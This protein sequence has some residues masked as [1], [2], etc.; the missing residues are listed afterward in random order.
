MLKIEELQSQIIAM[1]NP[2]A[3][4]LFGSQAKGTATERSDIDL[5]IIAESTNKR[6]LLADLYYSVET[7]IPVDFILYTPSEWANC[8]S[9]PHSF[10]YKIN[11]EGV[12]LYG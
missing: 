12:K 5:C 11:S 4:F 2:L 6:R 7:S 3:V 8:I 1:C 10:A 9:D